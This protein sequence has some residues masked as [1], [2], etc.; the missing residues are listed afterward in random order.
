MPLYSLSEM[1]LYSL[2]VQT[3][4]ARWKHFCGSSS[5]VFVD[6]TVPQWLLYCVCGHNQWVH[7]S[8]FSSALMIMVRISWSKSLLGIKL[9]CGSTVL[10][11][12][13]QITW[14]CQAWGQTWLHGQ[15]P[16]FYQQGFEKW[17]IHLEECLLKNKWSEVSNKWIKR[18]LTVWSYLVAIE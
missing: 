12:T 9:G 11:Q 16:T 3:L 2:K 17:I 13:I 14:W 5:I 7:P 1:A 6:D 8:F 4:V 18:H 10:R 15:D